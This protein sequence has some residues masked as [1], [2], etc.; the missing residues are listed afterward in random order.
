MKSTETQEFLS[1]NQ[2]CARFGRGRSWLYRQVQTGKFPAPMRIGS[3]PAGRDRDVEEWVR[4]C[5]ETCV[6]RVPP[7]AIQAGEVRCSKKEEDA[8]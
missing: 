1:I 5:T 3:A 4:H 2:I 8:K 7:K 6:P